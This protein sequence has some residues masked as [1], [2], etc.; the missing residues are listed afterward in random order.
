MRSQDI[1]I[2]I[3]DFYKIGEQIFV[4]PPILHDGFS[5][6]YNEPYEEISIYLNTNFANNYIFYNISDKSISKAFTQILD[7]PFTQEVIPLQTLIL[8]ITE[9]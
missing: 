5:H 2:Y 6:T 8:L 3:K 7:Y 4:S 9:I 1:S